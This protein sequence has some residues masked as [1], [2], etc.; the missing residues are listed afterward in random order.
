MSCSSRST[1]LDSTQAFRLALALGHGEVGAK[2]EQVVLDHAEH[3]I[4]RSILQMHPHDADRG[5]G[6]VHGS[7]G[8]DAQ[9]VFR[10]ALAR[11]ERGGAVIA[12]A[13]IDAIEHD[14]V[15]LRFLVSAP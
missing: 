14:H 4:E 11:A 2:I 10:A 15:C 5:V 9:I 12:G 3:R 13:R 7:V 1:W 8:R 6:L